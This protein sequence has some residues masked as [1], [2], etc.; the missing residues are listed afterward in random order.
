MGS[1]IL[2]PVAWD[3]EATRSRLLDAGVRQFAAL[4][5][6]GAR[7]DAIARDAGI[8]KERVYRYFGDKQGLFSAVLEHELDALFDGLEV[9]VTTPEGIGEFTGRMFDRCLARPELPRLLIWESLEL[10]A[11]VAADSRQPVCAV[12][13]TRI[14]DAVRG[15]GRVESEHL[16]LTAISVV[17]G[18]W[19]LSRLAEVVLTDPDAVAVRRQMVVAQMTALAREAG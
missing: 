11:P 3:T 14:C 10:E 6:A 1:R 4:G 8:N 13:A 16:L 2:G 12:N 19:G 18:W 17:V 7:I 15:L 5:F 9:E